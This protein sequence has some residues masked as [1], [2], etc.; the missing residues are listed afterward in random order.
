MS[1]RADPPN[2]RQARTVT[3]LRFLR[4]RDWLLFVRRFVTSVDRLNGMGCHMDI[5]VTGAIS[6]HTID[7]MR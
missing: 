4:K 7:K 3:V 1:S 2:L 6:R 5:D